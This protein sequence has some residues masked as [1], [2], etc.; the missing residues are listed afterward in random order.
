[1]SYHSTQTIGN[2]DMRQD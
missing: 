1:M 2:T